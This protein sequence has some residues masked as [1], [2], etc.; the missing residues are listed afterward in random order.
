MFSVEDWA[1]VRRLRRSE[2]L[3]IKAIVRMTGLSRNTVRAALRS[4][5]PPKYERASK[6]SLVD[7][8]EPQIRAQLALDPRMPATVIAQRIGWTN[9]MT[10]LKDRVRVIRPEYVGI[11]PA[12]RVVYR[13]GESAQMD[14]C[15]PAT[16]VPTGFG[17]A[18]ILPVLVMTLTF[19]R[20][21]SAMMIPS[22]PA[23]DIL[24]GMWALIAG[25]GAVSKTLAWDREAAIGGS[26]RLTDAARMFAGTLGTQI[27]LPFGVDFDPAPASSSEVIA[28]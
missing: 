10:I 25:I 4:E 5:K 15:F 2:G 28:S 8:V 24:A 3:P 6:G 17:N 20:F 18:E 11:D 27:V 9:S 21:L 14:L 1:E 16:Q 26:G 13:P 22:R 7:P 12:D 23:G 19:S